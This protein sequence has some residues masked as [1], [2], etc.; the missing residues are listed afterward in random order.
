MYNERI[1]HHTGKLK[2]R[3]TKSLQY[4]NLLYFI[5]VK[6]PVYLSCN[7]V[8]IVFYQSFSVSKAKPFILS[9]VAWTPII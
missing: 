5:V 7:N 9:T 3:P 4:T 8:D 2:V 6:T 1:C